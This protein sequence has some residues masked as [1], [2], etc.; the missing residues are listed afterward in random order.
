MM[1]QGSLVKLLSEILSK[2]FKDPR[3][4]GVKELPKRT[5]EPAKDIGG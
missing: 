5:A 3:I 2:G 1:H 4:R